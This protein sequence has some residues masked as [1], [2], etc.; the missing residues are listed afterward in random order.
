MCVEPESMKGVMG[1]SVE[2]EAMV[3]EPGVMG[4]N[5]RFSLEVWPKADHIQTHIIITSLNYKTIPAENLR[6][7]TIPYFNKIDCNTNSATPRFPKCFDL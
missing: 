7:S 5:Q 1:W 3:A 4:V 2:P 6:I